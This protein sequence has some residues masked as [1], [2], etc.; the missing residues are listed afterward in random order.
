[1]DRRLIAE[2]RAVRREFALSILW[3]TL[4]GA[5]LIGGAFAF[6]R[7]VAAVFLGGQPLSAVLPLLGLFGGCALLRAGLVWA[8]NSA[9]AEVSIRVRLDL[10]RRLLKQLVQLG[11]QDAG[12]VATDGTV[13]DVERRELHGGVTGSE[14]KGRDRVGREPLLQL[15]P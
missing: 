3:Q 7:T 2:A 4:A 6:S 9:A 5:C 13:V 12:G 11:A 15:F 1:M 14:H 8:G 10:R